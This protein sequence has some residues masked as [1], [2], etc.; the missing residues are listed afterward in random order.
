LVAAEDDPSGGGGRAGRR[1]QLIQAA[2]NSTTASNRESPN[3][4]TGIADNSSDIRYDQTV[5]RTARKRRAVRA[6]RIDHI[7]T[8]PMTAIEYG[9]AIEALAILIVQYMESRAT[10]KEDKS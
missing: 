9:D 6:L 4:V 3:R 5:R 10:V 2:E 1:E 8:T 7:E